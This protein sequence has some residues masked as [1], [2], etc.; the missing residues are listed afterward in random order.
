M[1]S[2]D[3]GQGDA[4][5]RPVPTARSAGPIVIRDA[6]LPEAYSG[7]DWAA[8][9]KGGSSASFLKYWHAL[10]KYRWIALSIFVATLVVGIIA[11]LL[12]TPIYTASTTLQIERQETKILDVG[13]MTPTEASTGDEFFQTQYGLLKSE[14][15]AE[16]VVD[17]LRLDL[18]DNFLRTMGVPLDKKKLTPAAR[19]KAA[20]GQLKKNLGVAPTRGSRLV[21]VTFDSPKPNISARIANAFADSFITSNLDRRYDS[22]SYARTFLEGRL[23]QVKQRLED[24]ERQLVAYAGQQEIINV[25]EEAS[26]APGAPSG[27]GKSLTS[28]NLS[29]LNSAFSEAQGERIRAEQR[30]RQAQSTPDSALPEALTNPTVQQLQQQQ[31]K[32]KATYQE[33]LKL[34]KPNFPEMTALQSQIDETDRQIRTTVSG[35]RGA[36]RAQYETALKQEQSFGGRVTQLKGSYLDLRERSIKYNILQREVDTNRVLYDGLLQRYKEVGV[37]GGLA[38]LRGPNPSSTWR[39]PPWRAWPWP[40]LPPWPSNTSM[41]PSTGRRISRASWVYPCWAR[42]RCSARVLASS[43]PW[44]IPD[45]TS[46]RPTTRSEQPCSSRPWRV[47]RPVSC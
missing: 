29:A 20:I 1:H 27:G 24:S 19:R 25:E 30:W 43:R 3:R 11:T 35:I 36:L 26:S 6:Q 21:K 40:C 34:Y 7:W 8:P 46:P 33:N 10:I 28:S 22:S 12:M 15:L 38:C 4:A 44:P 13:D 17:S 39:S 32:L 37:A 31:A 5:G 9:D 41:N 18:D 23:K 14:S 45:R 42:C 16:R 2:L 47:C